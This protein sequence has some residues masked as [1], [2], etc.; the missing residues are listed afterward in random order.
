MLKK[1]IPE[2]CYC[3]LDI[4]AQTVKASAVRVGE[5]H[6]FELLGVYE[7]KT[8]GFQQASVTDINELSEC[9]HNTVAGIL[10]RTGL[11]LK[12]VQLGISGEL[13]DQRFSTA[14]IPLVDRGNKVISQPDV[15][16]LQVQ[17][18]M[19]GVKMEEI[20]LHDFPQYYKVDDVNTALNPV[21]LFG[22]KLETSTLLIVLNNTILR[23]LT[24]AVN[25]A[26]Y[27]VSNMFAAGY[28][29]AEACLNEYYRRQGCVLLDVGAAVSSALFFKDGQLKFLQRILWGGDSITRRIS[30]QLN[31]SFN[32]A[33]DIKTAY[34]V[35]TQSDSSVDEEILLKREEAYVPV[36]KQLISEAIEPEVVLFIEQVSEAIKNSGLGDQMNVGVMMVGGG[37]LLPGFPE[38]LE[39]GLNMPVKLGKVNMA[40]KKLHNSAKFASVV[41]LAQ[42]GGLKAASQSVAVAGQMN[43]A[44]QTFNKVKELYQ[45]YF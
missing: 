37:S 27:D 39:Q 44:A 38:R 30:N 42:M 5:N 43:L 1:F 3:G 19:L 26:G 7:S 9:I 25:E 41:G 22:R 10:S 11:K 15:K 8:S 40:I 32:V 17:A 18:R 4:G 36:R 14:V 21:G 29:A 6:S 24:K 12:E 23:N 20:I 13:I 45:E 28:A 33:E 2:R 34:G 31:L 35:A 16:K